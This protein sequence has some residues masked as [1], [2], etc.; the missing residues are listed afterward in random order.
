MIYGAANITATSSDTSKDVAYFYEPDNGTVAMSPS[1][2]IATWTAPNPDG[3]GTSFSYKQT[4]N[5][6]GYVDAIGQGTTSNSATLTGAA[7]GANAFVATSL[8]SYMS[9]SGYFDVA[10]FYDYTKGISQNSK[11]D[12]AYMYAP[13]GA[14]ASFE[15]GPY[16]NPV[17]NQEIQ[18]AAYMFKGDVTST[19]IPYLALGFDTVL[20]VGDPKTP[21]DTAA[22]FDGTGSNTFFA[23]GTYGLMQQ[24]T[25][26]IKI[27]AT[28][29]GTI[30]AN[31]ENGNNDTKDLGSYSYMLKFINGGATSWM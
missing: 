28:E 10:L 7:S 13:T 27:S 19:D 26:G 8:Y 1:Q 9:G 29:F 15:N 25:A 21:T 4:G 6:F 18:N 11:S 20:A 14:T 17:N 30:I 16:T 22:L 23:N 2:T 3:S 31:S 24:T 12:M 5:D